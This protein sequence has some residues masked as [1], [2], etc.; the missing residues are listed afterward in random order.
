MINSF[1][2][3]MYLIRYTGMQ[4]FEQFQWGNDYFIWVRIISYPSVA[5]DME[6]NITN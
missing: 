6:G 2:D 5:T 3:L 4:G 1:A